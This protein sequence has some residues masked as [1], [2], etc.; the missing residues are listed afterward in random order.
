MLEGSGAKPSASAADWPL[1]TSYV[2]NALRSDSLAASVPFEQTISYDS[3][4]IGYAPD[5]VLAKSYFTFRSPASGAVAPSSAFP[6]EAASSAAYSPAPFLT[7]A[8]P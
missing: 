5:V 1:E 8:T 4:V 3:A 2:R 6:T 7:L